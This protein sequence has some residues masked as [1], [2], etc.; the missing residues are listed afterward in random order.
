LTKSLWTK[1]CH[2]T[3]HLRPKAFEFAELFRRQ[4][5][6]NLLL[7]VVDTFL[8]FA[9]NSFEKWQVTTCSFS[10]EFSENLG[11]LSTNRKKG[12][13]IQ[14]RLVPALPVIKRVLPI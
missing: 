10:I 5:S 14:K 2:A 4:Q 7:L 9:Q 13:K 11:K 8:W 12:I 6:E 1:K 3:V